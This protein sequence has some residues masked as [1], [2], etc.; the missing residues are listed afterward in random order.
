M[1]ALEFANQLKTK[2]GNLISETTEFRN[3]VTVTVADAEQ[4]TAVAAFAKKE[5]G[6]D[7][8]VDVI[9]SWMYR[10]LIITAMTRVGP[11][12]TNYAARYISRICV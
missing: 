11:W 12:F 5:L 8:L 9:Y 7:L 2:F 3:E 10:A 1:N 6:F 4:I